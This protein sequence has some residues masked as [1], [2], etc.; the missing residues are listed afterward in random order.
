MEILRF[1]VQ[2]YSLQFLIFC[3]SSQLFSLLC[4]RK[5]VI[6]KRTREK[7]YL[8]NR[9]LYTSDYFS[10]IQGQ[11]VSLFSAAIRHWCILL[12][13]QFKYQWL[14]ILQFITLNSDNHSSTIPVS[15]ANI[16]QHPFQNLQPE[17]ASKQ[18]VKNHAVAALNR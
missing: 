12:Q 2:L 1:G 7:K 3:H 4:I 5:Y 17:R 14:N 10:K 8:S 11:W 15:T 6:P 13:Q 16:F 18:F 9:R